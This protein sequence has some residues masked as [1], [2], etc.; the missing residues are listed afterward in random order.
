MGGIADYSGSLVAE[1]PIQQAVVVGAQRDEASGG[2]V[3]LVTANAAES[4]LTAKVE[5]PAEV[6]TNP[7]SLLRW[8]RRGPQ[9]RHWAGYA[10]GA[11]SILRAE[12]LVPPRHRGAAVRPLRCSALGPVSR[13]RRLSRSP[14]CAPSAPP[15]VPM[16][17][18]LL[19]RGTA[20]GLNTRSW[21][22]PAASWIR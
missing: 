8:L 14:L 6:F 7:V 10:A 1:M 9:E 12:G 16:T 11:L 17:D 5:I 22:P 20:S 4:G 15:R 21:M 13:H 3:T 19:L 18:G 2:A